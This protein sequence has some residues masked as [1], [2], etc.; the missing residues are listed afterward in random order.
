MAGNE[1]AQQS[2][3]VKID[4]RKP[5]TKAPSA[6]SVVRYR[7]AKL[8]YK[9]LDTAPSG[10]KATVNIKIH[11]RLGKVVKTLGPYKGIAVNRAPLARRSPVGLRQR[12]LPLLHL[13][14][15]RRPAISPGAAV[16]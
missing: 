11:N 4:T 9:V 3:H 12:H 10:G 14:L 5:T 13:R 16:G 15:R 2:F 8:F 7:T 6:A 1:G